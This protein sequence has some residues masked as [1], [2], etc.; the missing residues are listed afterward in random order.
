MNLSQHVA[1]HFKEVH[2]GVNWT[3][4]N[5]KATLA[6]VTWEQATTKVYDCNTI[7]TLVYHVNY[8]VTAVLNVLKGNPMDAH[9]KFSFSHPP[10]NSKE[11]WD[12]MLERVWRETDE[13]AILVAQLPEEK[14]W[15]TF[16]DEKYGNYYRNLHGIIEHTHYHM[17]QIVIIKKIVQQ[18]ANN[19]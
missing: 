9:D 14:M 15:E 13:F 1:K 10:I 5:L 16:V 18:Q 3:W 4:V 17:G 8:F 19:Q 2:Y 7:A 6:D 12:N 11:D